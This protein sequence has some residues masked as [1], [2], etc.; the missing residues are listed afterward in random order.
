MFFHVDLPKP[1]YFGAGSSS[2]KWKQAIV[3]DF[4]RKCDF[5]AWKETD[6]N[7]WFFDRRKTTRYGVVE[8]DCP[9]F[10]SDLGRTG[11]DIMQAIVAH[12][13]LLAAMTDLK[14]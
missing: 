11:H 1:S 8:N 5:G 6:C 13:T 10:I 7:L 2:K 9:E 12:V 4:F 3:F 14:T